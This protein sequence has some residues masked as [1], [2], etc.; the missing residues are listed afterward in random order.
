MPDGRD[1]GCAKVTYPTEREARKALTRLIRFRAVDPK[2]EFMEDHAYHCQECDL[3]HLTSKS[4]NGKR[5][6]IPS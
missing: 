2:S 1:G 6:R 5:K 4:R 3:W